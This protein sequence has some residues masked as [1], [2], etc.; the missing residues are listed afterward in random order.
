MEALRVS[1]S[2]SGIRVGGG[3][4]ILVWWNSAFG[5]IGRELMLEAG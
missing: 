1:L 3:V 2:G 4:W 5:V